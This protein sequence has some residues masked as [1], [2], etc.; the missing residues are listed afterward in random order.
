LLILGPRADL[1]HEEAVVADHVT[2]GI[3]PHSCC[4]DSSC[5]HVI[6]R[7][8][9][10]APRLLVGLAGYCS[11]RRRQETAS[12]GTRNASIALSSIWK[13]WSGRVAA[14]FRCRGLRRGC[15]AQC[16]AR[17]RWSCCSPSRETP[18]LL[19]NRRPNSLQGFDSECHPHCYPAPSRMRGYSRRLSGDSFWPWFQL[20]LAVDPLKQSDDVRHILSNIVSCLSQ[21]L[22]RGLGA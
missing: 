15:V 13:H 17:V 1:L 3:E 14:R 20:F 7:R 5:A 22:Y 9:A 16:V 8:A 10:H 6:T 18:R 11:V 12:T 21:P 4:S 19:G 2:F